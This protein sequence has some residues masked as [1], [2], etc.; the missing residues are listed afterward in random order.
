MGEHAGVH[1]G[2]HLTDFLRERGQLEEATAVFERMSA[3][4]PGMNS[5]GWWRGTRTALLISQGRAEDA[6]AA[7]DSLAEHCDT[8]PDPARLWW[9]SLKAEALDLL[10]R[11]EEALTLCREELEATR[12]FGAPGVLGRTLRV[13]GTLEREAGLDTLREAVEVLEG[14]TARLEQAKALAAFGASLRRVRKPTEARE[15]LRRALEL[16]AVCGAEGL[17]E[18][19]RSEL[20]SAGYR[21]RRDALSG[22]GALT[23]R[24]RRVSDLASAG[25][26]NREIAQ[27]LYVT[28]K[29]VELH[30]SNSYR[31]LGI[32][33]RRELERAL[34]V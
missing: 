3:V 1:T 27:E 15:P 4:D 23:A 30:L 34:A 29:T 17:A 5:T 18:H 16:A 10:G 6:V 21:P 9:R 14:S 20:H 12:S 22:P 24:E 11:T 8:I 31:K 28:P 32:G 19:A 26:T 13:L 2:C 33:S 7:A 25:R